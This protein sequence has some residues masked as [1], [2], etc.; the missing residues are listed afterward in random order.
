[1]DSRELHQKVRT[2]RPSGD[3]TSAVTGAVCT[4]KVDPRYGDTIAIGA[5]QVVR[6][7]AD[8][9]DYRG[10]LCSWTNSGRRSGLTLE[11]VAGLEGGLRRDL[12]RASVDT[13]GGSG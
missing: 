8:Q 6:A 9:L 11:L 7:A 4:T 2:R 1:M 13:E 12:I 3:S 5:Q 10:R